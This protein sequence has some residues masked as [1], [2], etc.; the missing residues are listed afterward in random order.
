MFLIPTLQG[1]REAGGWC[2]LLSKIFKI[3]P[4][5]F[6]YLPPNQLYYY[7]SHIILLY[8]NY[9]ICEKCNK[10]TYV[11]LKIVLK[12]FGTIKPTYVLSVDPKR[13]SLDHNNA[14]LVPQ[15]LSVMLILENVIQKTSKWIW[16]SN[17]DFL[18]FHFNKMH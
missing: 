15:T 5:P 3:L 9:I 6:M 11:C 7:I 14:L 2:C 10:T 1:G 18:S 4:M 8:I 17:G 13:Q 12:S 16:V